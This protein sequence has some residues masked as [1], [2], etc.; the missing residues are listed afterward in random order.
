MQNEN[1]RLKKNYK[2]LLRTTMFFTFFSMFGLAAISE[3]LV[4]TL[5][6]EKWS[7]SITYLQL[8]CLAGMLYPLHSLNLNILQIKGRS[9]LFL[10]IE[11]IKKLL[12]I[13]VIL[14][15]IFYGIKIMIIGMIVNSIAG[16]YINSYWSGKLINYSVR[17]QILDI[18]PSLIM[19]FLN[20]LWMY[21]V[22]RIL[23]FSEIINLLLL[24]SLGFL[25]PLLFC[26]L[27]HQK[28]YQEVKQMIINQFN[29]TKN[30]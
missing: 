18:F 6:G 30:G 14:I 24:L 25:V 7:S 5:I 13:P 8:L 29:R 1:E 26:E 21:L 28:D 2:K 23:P 12:A 10:K 17:E 20:G 16:Y 19:S 27:I 9:D 11:I 22:Y 4:I 3:P 15:G